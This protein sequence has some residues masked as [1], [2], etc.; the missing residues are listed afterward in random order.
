M[1]GL[2]RFFTGKAD[3]RA[4]ERRDRILSVRLT[5][6][7]L[8]ALLL[9]AAAS[10]CLGQIRLSPLQVLG[11][12]LNGETDSV[13]GRIVLYSRLP[14]LLGCLL[15]GAAL[16]VSGAVIQTVLNN[17]LAAPNVIGVNAGAGFA[18]TLCGAL[19]PGSFAWI[20]AAA[21]LGALLGVLAVLLIGERSGASRLTLVLAGVAVSAI[22]SGAIELVVTFVPDALTAYGDFR[23]GGFSGVTL[24][25]LG[26]AAVGAAAGLAAVAALIPQLNVLTLGTETAQS[27]G[28]HVKIVRLT[29]LAAA[30]ALAGSA[31]SVAGLLGFVGLIV[32]HAVRRFTHGDCGCLVLYSVLGGAA[33]VMI[34]DLLARTLLLPW[35][36]PAGVVLSFAGGPFFLWLV[37]RGK[38]R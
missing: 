8:A 34:C 29:M 7:L 13:A 36:L 28:L 9:S 6:A 2:R 4:A 20:P 11:I 25:R 30:A 5:A 31:V 12:L 18:V 22:F 27:L 35:E 10:L 38:R 19:F 14:R 17:P 21:F 26:P 24:R 16:S 37:L 1:N 23:I 3:R 15:A 33:F 32:P